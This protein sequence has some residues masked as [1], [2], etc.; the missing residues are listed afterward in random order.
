LPKA[1]PISRIHT[2]N[3]KMPSS[4]LSI[5]D[6]ARLTLELESDAVRQLIAQLNGDFE[7]VVAC[8]L[9]CTGRVI[10]TGIGKSG[11]IAQKLVATL[12][13]TGTPAVFM[14]A[15]DAIHGDLG[16]VQKDDVVLCISKSG[17][18]PEIK[19]LTPLIQNL[20]VPLIG[21]VGNVDSHL[22]KQSQWVLDATVEKEACPLDLAPTSSTTAQMALG[23]ALATCLMEARGFRGED[24]AQVHP[25]GALGKRLYVRLADLISADRKPRVQVTTSLQETVLEMSAGRCGATA[26]MNGDDLVGIVTDGDVRRSIEKGLPSTTPAIDIMSP[27]PKVM[28][29]SQ[30][31]VAAFQ[32]MESTSITQ[33]VVV[34]D[35]HYQ[36]LVHLHDILKEGIY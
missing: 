5:L 24:F 34:E 14:H 15:A 11:I 23:D 29:S 4:T 6:R 17:N 18:S 1:T 10:I 31:A 8:L 13:S 25:G 35:G 19:A 27:S 3:Q 26:V 36:G 7:R 16:L 20:G 21:M 28:E 33:I 9:E 2:R 12:N 22:A 32:L 30:L